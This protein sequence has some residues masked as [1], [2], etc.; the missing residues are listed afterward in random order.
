MPTYLLLQTTRSS[1][2]RTVRALP[3]DLTPCVPSAATTQVYYNPSSHYPTGARVATTANVV[4]NTTANMGALSFTFFFS[5]P[6]CAGS[7]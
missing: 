6:S 3:C 1:G 7:Q 2:A 5:M 4:A